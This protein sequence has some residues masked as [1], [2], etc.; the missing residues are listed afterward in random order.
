MRTLSVIACAKAWHD[1]VVDLDEAVEIL[2]VIDKGHAWRAMSGHHRDKLAKIWDNFWKYGNVDPEKPTGR[3]VVCPDELTDLACQHMH[4]GMWRDELVIGDK[5]F[6][7]VCFYDTV[8]QLIADNPDVAALLKKHDLTAKQLYAAMVRKDPDM[9]RHSLTFKPGFEDAELADR[10]QQAGKLLEQV[11]DIWPA[12]RMV[13]DRMVFLDE[14]GFALSSTK[15]SVHK[16]WAGKEDLRGYDVICA[17]HVPG[18]KDTKVHF[19]V[20]V[21]SHPAFNKWNGIV[22]YEKTTGTTDIRR[23]VNTLGQTAEGPYEY[24]VSY[25]ACSNTVLPYASI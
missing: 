8:P 6:S 21:C 3:P 13:L 15:K 14:G 20:A 22:F 18:Q 24:H 2:K 25:T 17:P 5:T 7:R 4:E 19:M 10:K 11:A 23:S 16:V 12:S 1:N 9:I